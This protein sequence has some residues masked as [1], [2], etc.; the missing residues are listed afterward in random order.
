MMR[1]CL[2]LAQKLPLFGLEMLM[3]NVV[4]LLDF[5]GEKSKEKVS[6]LQLPMLW[7]NLG[8]GEILAIL[9]RTTQRWQQQQWPFEMGCISGQFQTRGPSWRAG[10]D[11]EG[12]AKKINKKWAWFIAGKDHRDSSHVGVRNDFEILKMNF[13]FQTWNGH[14]L[15]CWIKYGVLFF[16]KLPKHDLLYGFY[17]SHYC[18]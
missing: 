1:F 5:F 11:S 15:A 13:F 10:K 6:Y 7:P 4:W 17:S 3:M 2:W 14:N 9:L 18:F 16:F 12:D 8:D